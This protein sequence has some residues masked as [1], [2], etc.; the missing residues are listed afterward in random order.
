M[1]FAILADSDYQILD[2]T[3][4][5]VYSGRVAKMPD[6]TGTP[7]VDIAPIMRQLVPAPDYGKLLLELN[8][9]DIAST[10]DPQSHTFTL[11]TTDG[12]TQLGVYW[13]YDEPRKT[14]SIPQGILGGGIQDY[15][16]IFQ[17]FALS[18]REGSAK[19][20]D[21]RYYEGTTG[22][23]VYDIVN[24]HTLTIYYPYNTTNIARQYKVVDCLPDGWAILYYVDADGGIAWVIC[25]RKNTPTQN[26]ARAQITHESDYDNPYKFGIDNYRVESYE[27]YTLNTGYLTD[28]QSA[29]LQ[30]LFRS[31]KVW[32]LR[33]GSMEV[34][35]VV[36]TDTQQTVKTKANS[37]RLF[38]YTIKCRQSQTLEIFG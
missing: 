5:V 6:E 18:M 31:P 10:A 38:N 23:W 20:V 32:M 3:G 4:A 30:Y 8:Q 12:D 21:K 27:S 29:R 19:V 11:H 2:S 1:R 14:T 34:F 36:L 26:I 7:Q 16:Y 28:E 37:G 15:V 25:D 17:L 24:D 33:Q 13:A 22:E 9:S 35:S